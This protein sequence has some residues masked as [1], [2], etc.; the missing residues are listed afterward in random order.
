MEYAHCNTINLCD[1]EQPP[2]DSTTNSTCG[3]DNTCADANTTSNCAANNTCADA[4]TPSSCA[5]ENTTRT[6]YWLA[7]EI[8]VYQEMEIF[9]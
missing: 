3:D 6:W 4:N 2:D 5:D 9:S 8:Y 1:S 7:G